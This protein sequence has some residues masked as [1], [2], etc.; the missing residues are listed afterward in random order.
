MCVFHVRMADELAAA[1]RQAHPEVEV[2]AVT[3]T[4]RDP[5]G[6]EE[7][8]VLVANDFPPGLLGRCPRLRWLQLTGTG[9]DHVAAGEP[10]PGLLVTHAGSVP[11]RAVAEFVWM[12]LLALAKDTPALVRAQEARRW[13]VPDAR[14]VAGS[15]L[16]LVGLGRIG[17]EVARRASGFGVRVLAVTRSG[18]PS[19]L[20]ER[21]VASSR[22]AEAAAHADHLV[23][24]VPAVPETHGLVDES[25][26]AAL[27]PDATLINIARPSVLDLPALLRALRASRLRAALLDVHPDEPLPPESPLWLEERLWV[28]P[29]CAFRFPGETAELASLLVDNLARFRAGRP[30]RNVAGASFDSL[31]RGDDG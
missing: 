24:A 20:A 1:V 29:H 3:E 27:P 18:R 13:I 31:S 25:V 14:L 28:T 9:T 15:T 7:I 21:V 11:A 12:G 30:L 22:L 26:L 10:A 2:D 23:L 17:G 8:D 5:P 4:D 6:V 19:P 16:V